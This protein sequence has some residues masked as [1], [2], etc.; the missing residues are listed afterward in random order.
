MNLKELVALEIT[1]HNHGENVTVV[2]DEDQ[3]LA[4]SIHKLYLERIKGVEM[5]DEELGRAFTEQK[6]MFSASDIEAFKLGVTA[7]QSKLIEELKK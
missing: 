7:Y 5:T 2:W 1:H 3:R 6:T 4:D